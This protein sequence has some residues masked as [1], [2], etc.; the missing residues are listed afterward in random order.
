MIFFYILNEERIPN[1][2]G[3]V[4]R[5]ILFLNFIVNI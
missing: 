5:T 4:G 2:G 1:G 3:G